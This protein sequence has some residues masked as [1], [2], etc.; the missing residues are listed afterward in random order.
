MSDYDYDNFEDSQEERQ[1]T[2]GV[3]VTKSPLDFNK[4]S[5]V[6]SLQAKAQNK[7]LTVHRHKPKPESPLDNYTQDEASP[8]K[9]TIN[10]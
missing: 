4:A 3:Q 5:S 1:A 7:Q 9:P 6:Y 10:P 2:A 8:S